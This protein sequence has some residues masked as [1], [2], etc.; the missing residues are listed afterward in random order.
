MSVLTLLLG[1]ITA[2]GAG[3]ASAAVYS[4]ANR[5]K[6][7]AEAEKLSAE[8]ADY[9]AKAATDL[10]EK[11]QHQAER[12]E[13]RLLGEIQ[14]LEIRIDELSHAVILLIEQLKENNLEPQ[15]PDD[16]S[17]PGGK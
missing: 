16:F 10:L 14:R 13:T 11:A 2:A 6:T 1:I 15:L 7:S 8:A 12:T 3:L 4:Y 9:I 5:K 17:H